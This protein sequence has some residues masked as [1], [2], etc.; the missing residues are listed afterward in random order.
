MNNGLILWQQDAALT[1]VVES[2]VKSEMYEFGI[3]FHLCSLTPVQ[4]NR[5]AT[6]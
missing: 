5:T 6:F 3:T 1:D 2:G 4:V